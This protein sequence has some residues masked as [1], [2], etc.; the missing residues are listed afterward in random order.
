VSVMA[1]R[2][3][4]EGI[5]TRHSRGCGS[6][7]EPGCCDCRPGYQAQVY[8]AAEGRTIRRTFRTLADARAWRAETKAALERG[9]LRA[10]S[11]QTLEQAAKDWVKAANAGVIRTRSGDPYKPGALRGYEQALSARIVPRFGHL[12]TSAPHRNAVQDLID[13]MLAEAL[14][15]STARNAILPRRA[16]YRRLT[17]RNEVAINPTL[18]L[19]LPAIRERRDRV[20]RPEEARAL[21]EALTQADRPPWATGTRRRGRSSQRAAQANAGSLWPKPLRSYLAAHRLRSGGALDDLVFRGSGGKPLAP[22]ALIERARGAWWDAG[23][24]PIGLHECRHTYAAFM[25]AAG[26]N[27]KALSSYM[28]HSTITMT[29]DRYGHLMPSNED[30]AAAMLGAYL[31]RDAHPAPSGLARPRQGATRSQNGKSGRPKQGGDYYQS[32]SHSLFRKPSYPS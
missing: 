31:E 28:G 20:A 29:L 30:E 26:V 2:A 3:R 17:A 16:I 18:G 1:K 10:P 19:S 24:E 11:R 23:L 9:S 15:P 6:Q 13:E 22:D 32:I 7:L 25:I 4:P 14:A 21:L 5:V 8:S 27:A 12:K